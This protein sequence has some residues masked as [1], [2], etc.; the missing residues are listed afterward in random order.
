MRSAFLK[1]HNS[2]HVISQA[3]HHSTRRSSAYHQWYMRI[4]L[5]NAALGD[6]RFAALF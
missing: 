2:R 5:E 6:E 3:I 4:R 1:F